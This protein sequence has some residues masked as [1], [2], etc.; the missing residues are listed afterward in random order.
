MVT[1]SAA[2]VWFLTDGHDSSKA[3]L[4]YIRTRWKKWLIPSDDSLVAG[5]YNLSLRMV[6][7]S[8]GAVSLPSKIRASLDR[9]WPTSDWLS[10]YVLGSL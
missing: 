6:D 3:T 1:S 5:D 8:R 9:N 4:S 2:K 7:V 10:A